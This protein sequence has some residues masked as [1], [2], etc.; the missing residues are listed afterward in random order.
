[1][2]ENL[3]ILSKVWSDICKQPLG[4]YQKL[5]I[6]IYNREKWLFRNSEIWCWGELQ[7]WKLRKN[8]N[9][10]KLNDIRFL[11]WC[12]IVSP[13][14]GVKHVLEFLLL[15]VFKPYF[16]FVKAFI[17]ESRKRGPDHTRPRSSSITSVL[18]LISPEHKHRDSED[19][20]EPDSGLWNVYS[21][22]ENWNKVIL[23]LALHPDHIRAHV[24]QK[25]NNTPY[26][27]VFWV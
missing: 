9:S 6:E 24:T 20:F 26:L 15:T 22:C 10:K 21:I 2:R 5:K 27:L 23:L 7:I 8:L 11:G 3:E 12:P 16:R 19:D 4:I 1:M 25:T 17:Y 13:L 18:G 14:K